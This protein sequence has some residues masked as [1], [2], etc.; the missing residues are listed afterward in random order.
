MAL[1]RAELRRFV[2]IT[3]VVCLVLGVVQIVV[4]TLGTDATVPASAE[5][6]G[7]FGAGLLIGVGAIW[8]YAA[9]EQTPPIGLIRVLAATLAFGA[10][11]RVVSAAIDGWPSPWQTVQMGIEFAV[12]VV[13]VLLTLRSSP[14][15]KT[16]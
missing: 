15:N 16:H 6:N 1:D 3:G 14:R 7:R 12:P 13:V 11:G 8:L 10:I 2:A 4:G 5:S 9:R